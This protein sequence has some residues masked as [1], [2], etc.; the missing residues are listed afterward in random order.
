LCLEYEQKGLQ[1][2]I[3]RPKTFL[4]TERLG[5]F[6]LWFEAIY[7]NRRLFILGDGNNKYQLLAVSDVVDAIIKAL[8]EKIHGEIF[9]IGA[10]EFYTWRKDL[11]HVIKEVKSKSQITSLP[12]YPSQVLLRILEAV[13]LSPISAWH[14][15]TMPVPSYVS[16]KKAEKLLKWH[17]KKS[18]KELFLESYEWYR[19]NRQQV[20]HRI[21]QTHRVGWNFKILTLLSK[22]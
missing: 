10:K 5:V 13:N 2:N 8:T 4:G 6:E 14:Y 22:I 19:K 11:G 15:L 17:P 20:F 7:T 18:N 9:N 16:I 1:V 12:V 3:L 21:G